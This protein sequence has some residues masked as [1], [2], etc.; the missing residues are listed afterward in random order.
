[1]LCAVG[2]GDTVHSAQQA[3]YRLAD[4]I[5]WEGIQFRRDIGY[6]AVAREQSRR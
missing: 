2:L 5:Q 6:R 3:A 1:V 4:A